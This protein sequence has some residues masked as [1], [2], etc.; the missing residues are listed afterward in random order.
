MAFAEFL[1]AKYGT[2]EDMLRVQRTE[3]M[4]ESYF[5]GKTED[6]VRAAERLDHLGRMINECLEKPED[7]SREMAQAIDIA[8][9]RVIQAMGTDIGRIHAGLGHIGQLQDNPDLYE[10]RI[11]DKLTHIFHRSGWPVYSFSSFLDFKSD[12]NPRLSL[13]GALILD[14]LAERQILQIMDMD[15]WDNGFKRVFPAYTGT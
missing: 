13:W 6:Y 9:E 3:I 10:P 12:G 4:E 7:M 11:M 15:S 8:T 1:G 14:R 5:L 2:P